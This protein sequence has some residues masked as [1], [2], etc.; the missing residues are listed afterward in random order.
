MT[1]KFKGSFCHQNPNCVVTC[2]SNA[3]IF[4]IL[5]E[6]QQTLKRKMALENEK[7]LLKPYQLGINFRDGL[8]FT[9]HKR[10]YKTL[11]LMF[12][13]KCNPATFLLLT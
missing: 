10:E 2:R 11:P 3:L 1:T 12:F 8:L 5:P 9:K 13:Q 6:Y 4:T 7:I